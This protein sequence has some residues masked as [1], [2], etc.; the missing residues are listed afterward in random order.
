MVLE[1]GDIDLA[2][3][4]AK[5]EQARREGGGAD[6]LDENFIRLYWQQMLQVCNSLCLLP[7]V[8]FFWGEMQS[9]RLCRICNL[10]L[11]THPALLRRE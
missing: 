11:L 4:L 8:D 5:H 10:H 6:E 2:R 1:Y 3:L 9:C 7:F